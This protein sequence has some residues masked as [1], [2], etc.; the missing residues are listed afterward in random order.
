MKNKK[1]RI[2][3]IQKFKHIISNHQNELP[4]F[5][6]DQSYDTINVDT[7]SWFNIDKILAKNTTSPVITN[8]DK[9][10]NA[11]LK[12]MNVKMILTDTHKLILN[13]WFKASTLIYNKTLQYIRENFTFTKKEINKSILLNHIDNSNFYNK[14]YIRNQM[15][16]IK[17]DIQK[18]F[19]LIINKDQTKHKKK[20]LKCLIDIHTLDKTIF[21]LVTN[22][23]SAKTNMMLNNIKRFRL[24]FWKYTRPSQTMEF[25]KTKFANGIFCKSIFGQLEDIKYLYN[26]KEYKITEINHDFKINHNLITGDYY[27][28]IPVPTVESN[29]KKRKNII[30][31]DPGLRTMM[32]GLNESETL[33]IGSNI[34]E[35]I[36]QDIIKINKIKENEL[37][38]K[39]IKKKIEL[40]INKKIKNKVDDL[41]WKIINYLTKNYKT[42]FLGN[43]SAKSIVSNNTSILSNEM[44][45]ACLRT[46]YFDFRLRLKYKCKIT[47][48]NFK[49]VDEY[50]T[51]KTC[52]LCCNYNDKLKGEK[53]YHCLSCN[54]KIDRDINACRNIYMRQ[55]L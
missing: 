53:I 44:K 17:K 1:K 25:E 43:M 2:E 39:K 31:L 5:E 41:H 19:T 16:K 15:I 49:L 33:N 34:N 42:I 22:I 4:I 3:F 30:V 26:N 13:S 54:K 46:R 14:I 50:Y 23:K 11:N 24:K 28:Y 52:S 38:P 51:S 45:T 10:D 7:F 36:K 12:M 9:L 27:L 32:T 55:Y 8:V 48:T 18:E 35:I 37:I 6:T 40:R 20:N 47:N 21:Q 29:V